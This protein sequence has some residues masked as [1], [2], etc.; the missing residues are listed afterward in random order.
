MGGVRWTAIA[1][2]SFLASGICGSVAIAQRPLD[3][4]FLTADLRSRVESL[5]QS[6]ATQPTNPENLEARLDTLW[7][8]INAY[9][10]TGGPVPVNATLQVATAYRSLEA[11]RLDGSR[12]T[13][14]VLKS[15]DDLIYEF[16]LKD[17]RPA[18]LGSVTLRTEGPV[19]VGS[20]ATIEQSYTVGETPLGPGARV[21][22]AKQL[23]QDGGLVQHDD[24]QAPHYVSARTSNPSVRLGR[25]TFPLSGMHG[26]FRAP[27]AMPAFQVEQGSLQTGDTLTLVYGDRESGSEG[28]RQQTFATDESLLPIYID[29]DGSGRF[30]TPRWSGYE[31]VGNTAVGVT[32]VAPSIVE[33]GE[34]FE[35]SIR[36]ED[37]AGNRATGTMP[38]AAVTLNGESFRSLGGGGEP[39]RR[40]ESIRLDG[41]GVYRFGI[42]SADGR[43]EALS[44]PVWV[45]R[46][47]PY[48]LYWGETHTHT[49]MAEGQGSIG[50]SYQFAQEDARLDF[51]GLSEHDIW[52][53]DR[54]WQAMR[55]AV[56]S[57]TVPGE[58]VAFL[59]Y[60]WTLRRQWGGHHN[61]F[62][63]SPDSSRVG[64]QVAPTL[65]GLYEGLRARY[66]TEDVLIIPH[67]HQAGDW[68]TNDPEMETMIEIMSMHG[69]FEWFGNYYLRQGH[70][71]GFLAASDD[72]R[73]RPGYSWTSSRQPNSSLSQFGGLAGVQAGRKTADAIF[74][75]LKRRQAYAVTDAQRI[76]LEMDMNGAGMGDRLGFTTK[77]R[78]SARVIGTS[79]IRRVT[80]VKNGETVYAMRPLQAGIADKMQLVVGF[81]SSSEPFFRDN[82]R[83]YRP[84]QGS[85][86]VQGARLAA[87]RPLHFD[88]KHKEWA[89]ISDEDPN[90][91]VFSTGTRGQADTLLLDLEGASPS[92]SI[93]FDLEGAREWGKSPVPVRPMR[94]VPAK[95]S[96]IAL[97]ELSDGFARRDLSDSEDQ[98]SVTLESVGGEMPMEARVEFADTGEARHGDY[99]YVRVDQLDGARAYSSPVWVGGEPRR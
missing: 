94:E 9:S 97:R 52:L 32:A 17:E 31:I 48:R 62:F 46:N 29:L 65:T 78:L 55:Q 80:V 40:I 10:L 5:K 53:D 99:Y 57:N 84:W 38:E 81:R 14:A 25:T 28:W 37:A 12:P 6:A 2:A 21:M 76:I 51:M 72:H 19:H 36:W 3:S 96:S 20:W 54:E 16:R 44:N 18:A 13:R 98:D 60:E 61:V 47:P 42:R 45:R 35:L 92:T 4:D 93:A 24:P 11:A 15:V 66:G 74:D 95:R 50:R 64:A 59:G 86:T 49:G 69:T 88:N 75:A 89:R 58:F 83:G 34:E 56:E 73:S 70:Q 33:P 63:R 41:E 87:M 43:I 23:Q 67:A 8:W 79:P 90:T 85:L 26:G 22:V 77:R 71:V 7:P 39:I 1:I 27:R 68:R 82:P 30:L 91:V